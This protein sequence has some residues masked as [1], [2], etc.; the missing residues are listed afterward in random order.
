MDTNYTIEQITTELTWNI[1]HQV[2]YPDLPLSSVHIEDDFSG[3]HFGLFGNN[4]L[5]GVVS[6]FEKDDNIVFR[7]LAISKEHQ[8][9]KLGSKLLNHIIEYAKKAGKKHISCNAR[10]SAINFYKKFGFQ[11]TGNT[12]SRNGVDFLTIRKDL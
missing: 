6:L 9:K 3:V 5:I 12:F 1:R 2:L 7:N 8:N 11:T 4:Q 10:I